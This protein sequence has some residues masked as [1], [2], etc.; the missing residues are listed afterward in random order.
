[1]TV[2]KYFKYTPKKIT[3]YETR[4]KIVKQKMYT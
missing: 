2:D 3:I 4:T 1:M